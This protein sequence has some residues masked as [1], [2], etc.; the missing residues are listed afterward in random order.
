MPSILSFPWNFSETVDSEYYEQRGTPVGARNLRDRMRQF[1]FEAEGC[2]HLVEGEP[3]GQ[4]YGQKCEYNIFGST[5]ISA[6]VPVAAV[7]PRGRL[8]S[9]FFVVCR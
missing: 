9:E 7:R 3:P 6:L 5:L 2:D 8:D 4:T 1:R